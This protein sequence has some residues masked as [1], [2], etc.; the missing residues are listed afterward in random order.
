MLFTQE[1]IN[2]KMNKEQRLA[3]LKVGIITKE[4]YE[5][6]VKHDHEVSTIESPN[7]LNCCPICGYSLKDGV[8]CM[9]CGWY[10]GYYINVILPTLKEEYESDYCKYKAILRDNYHNL[11]ARNNL[12]TMLLD[13]ITN[14]KVEPKLLRGGIKDLL[15]LLSYYKDF[16]PTTPN[17]G[18]LKKYYIVLSAQ[19]KMLLGYYDSAII[20]YYSFLDEVDIVNHINDVVS[21]QQCHYLSEQY[22]MQIIH[23]IGIALS[24]ISAELDIDDLL[25]EY[26][27]FKNLYLNQVGE[28]AQFLNNCGQHSAA[29]NVIVAAQDLCGY[30]DKK[31]YYRGSD[32]GLDCSVYDETCGSEIN[33]VL[34][35]ANR[36]LSI[37]FG[38]ELTLFFSQNMVQYVEVYKN[39]VVPPRTYTIVDFNDIN[40]PAQKNNIIS[41]YRNRLKKNIETVNSKKPQ[42]EHK[43]V[44]EI[45]FADFVVKANVFRCNY[46]HHIEQVQAKINVM[47][48][49]GSIITVTI[50]AGYCVICNCYF[51]LEADYERLR[52]IGVLLCQQITEA[53]YRKNGLAIMNGDDLKPESLLFQ[54]GYNVSATENLSSQQRQEILRRVVDCGLYSISGI[55]SHLDWLIARNKKVHN[56][57]MSLAI[58][59]WQEDRMVI[60]SYKTDKQRIVDVKSIKRTNRR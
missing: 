54:S 21:K 23:N 58:S 17:E 26:R 39:P 52:K 50:T 37:W 19:F 47:K 25:L 55:C 29:N 43:T 8:K 15:Y 16:I 1:H 48:Q 22:L 18:A 6:S 4:Q 34:L 31:I 60:S 20:D 53:S 59:K 30:K 41:F 57:D 12:I 56:R 3:L 24:C 44:Y 49:D 33:K 42:A 40:I 38:K 27:S 45:D 7:T 28:E 10:H 11:L 2:T 35:D 51:M 9:N 5:L 46:N 13:S 14:L 36:K 32:G